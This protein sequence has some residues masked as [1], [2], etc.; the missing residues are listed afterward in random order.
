MHTMAAPTQAPTMRDFNEYGSLEFVVIIDVRSI[1][2]GGS[3]CGG[4][5]VGGS[6]GGAGFKNFN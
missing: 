5:I 4:L 3:I 6:I 1:I 2:G